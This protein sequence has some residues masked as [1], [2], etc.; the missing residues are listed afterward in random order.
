MELFGISLS[1]GTKAGTR[2]TRYY[3]Y[4]DIDPMGQLLS[5][6]VYYVITA[7]LK[8]CPRTGVVEGL[9]KTS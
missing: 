8:A 4:Y 3:K 9:F 5:L 7:C 1:I 2:Y 6:Q